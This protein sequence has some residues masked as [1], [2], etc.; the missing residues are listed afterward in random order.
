MN[1]STTSEQ[2]PSSNPWY[3]SPLTAGI[4]LVLFFPAGLF[5]MWR[6]QHWSAMVRWG[7]TS[8]MVIAVIFRAMTPQ[9]PAQAMLEPTGTAISSNVIQS[10]LSVQDQLFLQRMDTYVNLSMPEEIKYL[11]PDEAKIEAAQYACKVYG[12]GVKLKELNLLGLQKYQQ[13]TADAQYILALAKAGA[14]TY[15]PQFDNWSF[16]GVAD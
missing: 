9:A 5:L 14:E 16:D 1:P 3:T 10:T 7:V 2:A 11:Y 12:R 6:Y 15:C 4:L 13:T 8:L